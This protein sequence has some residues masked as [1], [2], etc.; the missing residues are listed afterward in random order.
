MTAE[1]TDCPSCCILLYL[2][3]FKKVLL[4]SS[5]QCD[6]VHHLAH[7]CTIGHHEPCVEGGIDR[8]LL[9][10]I[11]SGGQLLHQRALMVKN[12]VVPLKGLMELPTQKFFSF[13]WED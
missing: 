4:G 13:C 3:G 5:P 10:A 12:V 8:D 6:E 11:D 2:K 9:Q 7:H 1:A